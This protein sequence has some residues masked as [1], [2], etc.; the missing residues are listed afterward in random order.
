M[1]QMDFSRAYTI[2]VLSALTLLLISG[3]S[4]AALVTL[5]F[6]GSL[7]TVT[8]TSTVTGGNPAPAF[9]VGSADYSGVIEYHSDSGAIVNGTLTFASGYTINNHHPFVPDIARVERSWGAVTYELSGTMVAAGNT[10]SLLIG[11]ALDP[12]ADNVHDAKVLD[13]GSSSVAPAIAGAIP[14]CTAYVPERQNYNCS[15]A[16]GEEIL[17]LDSLSLQFST[18]T[19]THLLDMDEV[20]DHCG[21]DCSTEWW[22]MSGGGTVTSVPVPPALWLFGS[23]LLVIFRAKLRFGP[24]NN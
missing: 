1:G 10:V 4:H 8:A 20:I 21:G 5:T 12:T 9:L 13:M 19:N 14:T 23:G 24:N 15:A 7:D 16:P 17:G 11:N 18:L 3:I 2:R 22:H 6:E